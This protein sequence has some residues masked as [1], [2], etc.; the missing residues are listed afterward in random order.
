VIEPGIARQRARGASTG[1]S[2]PVACKT[3][4]MIAPFSRRCDGR[5]KYRCYFNALFQ[6]PAEP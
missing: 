1:Q 2:G 3:V 6:V 5:K 4:D